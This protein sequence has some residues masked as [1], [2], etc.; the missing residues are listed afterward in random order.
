MDSAVA[1]A[2]VKSAGEARP[3]GIAEQSATTDPELMESCGGARSSCPEHM[4]TVPPMQQQQSLLEKLGLQGSR[5]TV[6]PE[7]RDE[8][9]ENKGRR[10]VSDEPF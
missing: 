4:T 5:S 3:P 10:N 1:T 7:E 9:R 8:V 6:S 2:A